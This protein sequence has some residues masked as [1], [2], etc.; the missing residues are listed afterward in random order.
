MVDAAAIPLQIDPWIHEIISKRQMPNSH[1]G[2]R[3]EG[4]EVVTNYDACGKT[5]LPVRTSLW[6]SGIL[7]SI[8]GEYV[9]TQ[10]LR[11][12]KAGLGQPTPEAAITADTLC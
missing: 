3:F 5:G 11:K 2:P 10:A 9:C 4:S 1:S 12:A 6:L 8:L 7:N